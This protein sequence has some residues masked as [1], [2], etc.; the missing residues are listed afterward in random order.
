MNTQTDQSEVLFFTA[1]HCSACKAM[2]PIATDVAG[3]FDGSVQLTEV[4]SSSDP[5]SPSTHRVR[6]VPTFIALHKGDE[7]ARVV[8]PR[9]TE[10]LAE[11]F[12]AA[13]SGNAVSARISQTD[14]SLRLVVGAVF[15]VAAVATSTPILWAFAIA[16]IG[17]A[18]WD[19]VRP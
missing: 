15:A 13:V 5:S 6:G 4:D 9:S 1:P 17:F 7:V 18:T 11:L 8:G 12:D 2:R 10:Q 16:A 3:R 14:R 19:L